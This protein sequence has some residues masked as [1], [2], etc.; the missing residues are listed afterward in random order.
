MGLINTIG[1]SLGISSSEAIQIGALAA[2]GNYVGATKLGLQ[3]LGEPAEGPGP[4]GAMPDL[5]PP[6]AGVDSPASV[7][8][9][10]QTSQF[11]PES[12]F[13]NPNI[14]SMPRQ[15]Q[16]QASFSPIISGVGQIAKRFLAPNAGALVGGAA[17]GGVVDFVMDQFGNARKLIIT[18][19]MKRE[20]TKM[21]MFMGG[22]LSATAQAYSNFKQR[23]YSEQNILSILLKT[24]SS[25]GPYVTKAAVRKTRST[26]RKMNVLCDI[27]K[28]LRPPARRAPARKMSTVVNRIGNK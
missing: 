28:D 17:A 20:V 10:S 2:T 25:Q 5:A 7:S 19:K 8:R 9:V 4:G 26:I 11:L 14:L 13:N 16:S 3:S 15:Q 18:R 6:P 27:T 1:K 22:D 21:Y 23:N 12:F 24:F